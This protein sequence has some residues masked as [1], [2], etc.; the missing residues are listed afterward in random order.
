MAKGIM[1][2]IATLAHRIEPDRQAV[3]EWIHG[4][5]IEELNGYTALELA[6]AGEGERV[7]ELLES[8][9]AERSVRS[10][11][12]SEALSRTSRSPLGE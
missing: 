4:T 11:G 10:E 12:V 3:W 6:F 5:P 2:R 1:R 8:I 9:V 7:V